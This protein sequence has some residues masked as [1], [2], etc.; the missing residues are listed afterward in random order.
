MYGNRFLISHCRCILTVRM[1]YDLIISLYLCC[2]IELLGSNIIISISLAAKLVRSSNEPTILIYKELM[3][4]NLMS[5]GSVIKTSMI[6]DESTSLMVNDGRVMSLS[7]FGSRHGFPLVVAEEFHT[8]VALSIAT[9]VE[10][11]LAIHG[12]NAR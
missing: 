11:I 8:L 3:N 6:N 12:I 4:T 7:Q 5:L 10:N 2:I 9:E 1:S